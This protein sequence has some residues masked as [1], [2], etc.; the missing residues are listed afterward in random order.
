MVLCVATGKCTSTSLPVYMQVVLSVQS[1]II[2]AAIGCKTVWLFGCFFPEPNS[3]DLAV[4]N[5]LFPRETGALVGGRL[6]RCAYGPVTNGKI[7]ARIIEMMICPSVS[8][9]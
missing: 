1:A 5:F 4:S 8:Q 3:T 9:F 6:C 7:S 2:D